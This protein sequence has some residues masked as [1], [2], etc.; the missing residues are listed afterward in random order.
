LHGNGLQGQKCVNHSGKMQKVVN[1]FTEGST[2]HDAIIHDLCMKRNISCVTNALSNRT[3]RNTDACQSN[4]VKF[5][6]LEWS[7][8]MQAKSARTGS[9]K[10]RNNK[11]G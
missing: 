10:M 4:T 1:Y 7:K 3:D 9:S 6:A 5:K 2:L 8:R 11:Y